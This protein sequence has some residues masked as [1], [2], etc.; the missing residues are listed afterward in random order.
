[1]EFPLFQGR[2]NVRVRALLIA[3]RIE[4]RALEQTQRLALA[5]LTIGAGDGGCAV[6][7]RYGVV[8][9]FGLAP[10][11]EV[12]FLNQLQPMLHN[13][14]RQPETEDTEIHLN[15]GSREGVETTGN[16]LLDQFSV[17]RLQLVADILAKSVVLANSEAVVAGV[18]DRIEPLAADLE[19]AGKSGRRGREL[20]RYI[21]GALLIQHRTVGRVEIV[22]K[23]ELLW[24][25]PELERIHARLSEEYELQERQ[26]SLESKLELIS[27][28][29]TTLL[30]LLQNRRTLRVEWYIVIL[31]V[32]EVLLTLYEMFVRH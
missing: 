12:S 14:L 6:L 32:V 31:I 11:D 30:E 19:R 4:L 9:L 10:I 22:E 1:M 8:V 7:F 28:T 26:I 16:I 21:G 18:F 17:E 5:P 13:P 2:Q 29:A 23:P 27:R 3:E 15:P 25:H 24:E 20:L